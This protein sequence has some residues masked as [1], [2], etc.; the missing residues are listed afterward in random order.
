MFSILHVT[1]ENIME[2]QT[3]EGTNK[4]NS[5]RKAFNEVWAERSKGRPNNSRESTVEGPLKTADN[6]V[7]VYFK[8]L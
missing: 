6:L 4:L 1:K 5:S 7:D 8:G 2:N 3:T